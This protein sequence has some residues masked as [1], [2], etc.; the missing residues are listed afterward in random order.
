[1]DNLIES[2]SAAENQILLNRLYT[3]LKKSTIDAIFYNMDD[4]H[5]FIFGYQRFFPAST[6][7][8][9]VG[10]AIKKGAVIDHVF[11]TLNFSLILDGEGFYSV[12]DQPPV[13]VKAPCVITQFP[14]MRQRYGPY[15]GGWWRELYLIYA[16]EG[17]SEAIR[18]GFWNPDRRWWNVDNPGRFMTVAEGLLE[19]ADRIREPGM[20][21]RMD[22]AAESAILESLLPGPRLFSKSDLAVL[23]I[24]A[25]LERDCRQ[26]HDLDHLAGEEGLSS[27]VFRRLW[28][29]HVGMPPHRYVIELR[30][31]LACRLLTE[32][33]LNI[34]EIAY[35]IGYTDPL[36]FSRLFHKST[37]L[38]A[39]FYRRTYRPLQE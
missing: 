19:L 12:D 23:R 28:K 2:I 16:P 10:H 8:R 7:V 36:Y 26:E 31:G 9:A 20:A 30:M 29:K 34:S 11:D 13:R 33:A 14:G 35:Q 32:T 21:D 25:I 3:P 15:E 39:S 5:M 17:V 22:R 18:M 27:S 4:F 37:G 6:K 24:K 1:M 38:S